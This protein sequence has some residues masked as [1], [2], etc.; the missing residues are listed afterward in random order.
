MAISIIYIRRLTYLDAKKKLL[1]DIEY[2]FFRGHTRAKVIH[3]IGTYT[4]RKMVVKE[5]SKIDYV[6]IIENPFSN[7]LGELEIELLVP[8]L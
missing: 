7:N 6:K 3:G 5:I 4:L 1:E 8:D 2:L